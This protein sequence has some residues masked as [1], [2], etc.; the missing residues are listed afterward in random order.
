MKKIVLATFIAAFSLRI[1]AADSVPIIPAPMKVDVRDGTFPLTSTTFIQADAEFK[2]EAKLLA[3]RLHRSTG[4]P[5]KIK[6]SDKNS[7]SDILLVKADANFSL[8]AEGYELSITPSN[9]VIRAAT[10]AGIFYG[11]Q[12][13]LQL[14]PPEIFSSSRVTNM[15]WRI[16]C[17]QIEDQPRFAWRGFMLD[18]SRHFFTRK[19]VEQVLDLM[20]LY[21]LNTFHWHLVDDQGWRIQI[22]KY[23]ELTKVGAWRDGIGFGLAP[24]ASWAYDN[25]GRYGGF[26]TQREIRDVVAYAAARHI[27]IVPEIE[28]P[29]HSSAALRAYPQYLCSEVKTNGKLQG[30]KGISK[31]VYC[32]GNDATFTFLGNVLSEVAGLFPGKYI[33]IGGDEVVKSNWMAC[34]DCQLRM[35]TEHLKD[36]R[37]LQAY[38]IHRIEGIVNA[39][40]KSLIGW[41]EIR[42]GGLAPSAALMDWIGGGA[43]SA[44][45]GHDVVMSPTKYCY[46]DHYQSTNH[47]IEPKAIGGF[48]PLERVYEFEPVPQ[49]LAPEFQAHV[50]GGQANLW[51]EYV[52]NL[53]QVEYMM[54][55]RLGALSEVDWSPKETRNWQDFRARA[56]LNEK[57]LDLMGVNY[58]PLAK[59]E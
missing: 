12:S 5:L 47:T 25:K 14:L 52:P 37:E 39:H 44:A 40:G 11:T 16:P 4:F 9:V 41:S 34:A 42:E 49:G 31:G 22:K 58:R 46:F 1:F 3:A 30:K 29:G 8:G 7:A 19:E 43:E 35:Q 24:T 50:L 55:P 54:F 10:A 17:V 15:D 36:G 21:K 53:R 27:T 18:V 56:A 32:A 45:S 59:P 57:R 26:Y 51:T 13:L 23:P 2:N 6:A 20:A 48:L 33:H 38:F 28:M